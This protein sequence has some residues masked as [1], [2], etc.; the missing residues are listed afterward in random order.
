[1]QSPPLHTEIAQQFRPKLGQAAFQGLNKT[2]IEQLIS[3]ILGTT[4]PNVTCCKRL[5]KIIEI[6]VLSIQLD[7]L[8]NYYK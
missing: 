1:M 3:R 7:L 8:E 2:K 5:F 6:R 4:R